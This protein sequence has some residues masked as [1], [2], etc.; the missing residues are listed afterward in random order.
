MSEVAFYHLTDA[1]LDA[2]LPVL[3][4]RSLERG[5]KVRVRSTG[6]DRLSHLDRH[7]WT[8]ADDGFLPHG[9]AGGSHDGAQPILLTETEAN[10]NAADVLMLIDGAREE[11][12]SYAGYA[13]VCVLF[14]G[15]D[16]DAV[17]DA[18]DHWQAVKGSGLTAQYWAQD[19]GKWTKK[20]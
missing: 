18:R 19:N 7:L 9:L 1:T 4:Q 15:R 2:T 3:L 17:A 12:Q 20:A 8:F 10:T 11:L 6:A 5:W 13:R 16:A 14:D